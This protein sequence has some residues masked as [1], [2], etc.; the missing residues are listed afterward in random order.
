[1]TLV[2][3]LGTAFN[4][5]ALLALDLDSAV[6]TDAGGIQVTQDTGRL[7]KLSNVT[8]PLDKP[9]YGKIAT[10]RV[11]NVYNGKS[12]AIANQAVNTAGEK[13]FVELN[14]MGSKTDA[15][16]REILVPVQCRIELTVPLD[17]DITND[18]LDAMVL[19]TL[20]LT[21]SSGGAARYRDIIRGVLY[22]EF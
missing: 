19:A 1:M 2:L 13:I 22:K 3:N 20:A 10:Q 12:V 16:D 9:G 5:T 4:P 15:A 8:S 17:N 21:R 18:M 7:V 6:Y 14:T 11:A